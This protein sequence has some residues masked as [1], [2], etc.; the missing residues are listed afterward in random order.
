MILTA[1]TIVAHRG[2]ARVGNENTLSAFANAIRLDVDMIELD[3]HLTADNQL[4]VCHDPTLNRTTDTKGVIAEMTLD[5]FKRAH[6]LDRNTGMPTE[7]T[8]PTLREALDLIGHQTAILLEIKRPHKNSYPGI[9]RL[10]W[11][12][13]VETDML[14][15]V[16]VQSFDDDVL[17]AMHAI[18][19]EVKLEK[20]I[21]CRLPFGLVLDNRIHRFRFENYTHCRSI[22]AFSKLVTKAFVEEAHRAGLQVKV[23]TVDDPRKVLPGV[24]GVITNR[25][26]IFTSGRWQ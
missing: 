16:T 10:V 24:D 23:W 11:Q 22:N 1:I 2:G 21:I 8:L 5:E 25:P 13:L 14:E 17:T 19:P 26:D 12:M 9:E 4:V 7:E 20:L 6:A 15:S 18:A 3:V